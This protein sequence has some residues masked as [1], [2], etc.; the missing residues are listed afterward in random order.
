MSD[1]KEIV[2]RLTAAMGGMH[3]LNCSPDEAYK[4]ERGTCACYNKHV[5]LLDQAAS[6]IE[7]LVAERDSLQSR[8]AA[9][10]KDAE[11]YRWL[12]NPKAEINVEIPSIDG[13]GY[14]F[15]GYGDELDAAI[16]A[17]LARQQP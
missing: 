15:P 13:T 1:E 4:C 12:R 16:D 6:L 10:E 3:N 2:E 8:L 9:A 14:L 17:A 11:R 5:D 7:R